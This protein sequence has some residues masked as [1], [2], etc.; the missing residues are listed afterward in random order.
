MGFGLGCAGTVAAL[1]ARPRESWGTFPRVAISLVAQGA[2]FE[3]SG[4]PFATLLN[5]VAVSSKPVENLAG[6]K[7]GIP[8]GYVGHERLPRTELMGY[9]VGAIASCRFAGSGW[10]NRGYPLS[11]HRT[12]AL[13][14]FCA[15]FDGWVCRTSGGGEG[16]GGRD[17]GVST[18]RAVA[19]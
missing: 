18:L 11:F 7:D 14:S 3:D 2:P 19:H 15:G 6:M 8:L 12:F 17:G 16:I 10:G 5:R 1:I 4:R 9:R 13:C